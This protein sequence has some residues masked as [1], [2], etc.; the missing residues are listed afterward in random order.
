M[1][2]ST[3]LLLVATVAPR[4]PAQAAARRLTGAS[5]P[6][7]PRSPASCGWPTGTPTRC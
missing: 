7:S 4:Q 2:T 1:L 6:I 3:V 5:L